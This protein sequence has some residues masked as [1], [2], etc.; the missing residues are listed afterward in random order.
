MLSKISTLILGI[1]HEKERNPY[2]ITKMLKNLKLRNWFNVA[3]SSVYAT[4]NNLKK[5][6]L[7]EGKTKK[8][9]RF[10]EKTIYSITTEG[11]YELHSTISK[12]LSKND[13]DGAKFDIAIL[14]LHHLS[15]DEVFQKLKDK[16]ENLESSTYEI[17]SQI[18]NLERGRTV[19]F[20]GLLMLKHRLYMAETEIRTIKEIIREFNIKENI[21][22]PT[23]FDVSLIE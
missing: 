21:T 9:G 6:N 10:P 3:D 15:K 7:I 8:E 1:L 2:E 5:Q 16:L 4:I 12:Y 14:L 11:E 19:A 18:I 23:A 20:T 13:P 22:G 17:K